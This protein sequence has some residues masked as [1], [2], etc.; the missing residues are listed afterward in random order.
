M[1]FKRLRNRMIAHIVWIVTTV[2]LITFYFVYKLYQKSTQQHLRRD[3]VLTARIVENVLVRMMQRKDPESL[4]QL[5]PEFSKLYHIKRIRI[6]RPNG[7]IAFSSVAQERGKFLKQTRFADFILEPLDT[8]AY[9]ETEG[10]NITFFKW[11]K[12]RNQERC[13]KCHDS[14]QKLNGVLWV[15]ASDEVSL[16]ALKSDYLVLGGIALGVIVL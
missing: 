8:I 1:I 2:I 12:L 13:Q 4:N 3:A 11:R 6:V 5:L 9:H 10:Q 14:S 16:H 7:R 15:E